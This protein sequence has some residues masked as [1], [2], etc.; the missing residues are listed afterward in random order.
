MLRCAMVCYGVLCLEGVVNF[1][2]MSIPEIEII[3][4]S[5]KIKKHPTSKV[6]SCGTIRAAQSL[7]HVVSARVQTTI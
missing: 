6:V 5:K 3:Q 2:D 1:P 7:T 4:P